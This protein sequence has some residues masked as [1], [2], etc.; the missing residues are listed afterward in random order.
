MSTSYSL[1]FHPDTDSDFD[2]AYTWYKAQESNVGERF[3]EQL[4]QKLDQILSSPETYG[5]KS[6]RGYREAKLKD[7]PYSIVYKIHAAQNLIFISSIHH[8][9]LHPNKKFRKQQKV[10]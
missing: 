6:K 3:A 10:K 9:K 4:S 5:V 8:E 7:F 2:D 1:F